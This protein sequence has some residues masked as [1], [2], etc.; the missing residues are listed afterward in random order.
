MAIFYALKRPALKQS[1]RFCVP[2]ENSRDVSPSGSLTDFQGVDMQTIPLTSSDI[3]R[4]WPKV[5][6][7]GDCWIWQA[8]TVLKYGMFS[9]R[10]DGKRYM[11]KAHR[12][13][14][15]LLVGPIPDGHGLDHI[16]HNEACVKPSHLRPVTAKQNSE[17]RKGPNVNSRS[18]Y[19]GVHWQATM[20]KWRVVVGHNGRHVCGGYFTDRHEAGQV[21]Q[22]MRQE[23]FTHS[24]ADAA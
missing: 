18:G 14:Y 12:I 24:D 15:E 20:Q 21:A 9:V 17:H 7:T 13:S 2:K 23:L 22:R 16:C 6:K 4:F 8:A 3:A 1:G 10:I 19:R 5:D 11:K